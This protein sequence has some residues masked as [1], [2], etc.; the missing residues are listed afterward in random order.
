M[1][2]LETLCRG[3]DVEDVRAIGDYW[4]QFLGL[5]LGGLVIV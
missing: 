3:D 4:R 5:D 1:G 2:G